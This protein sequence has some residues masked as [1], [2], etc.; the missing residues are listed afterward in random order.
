MSEFKDGCHEVTKGEHVASGSATVRAYDSA[1]VRAYDSATVRAY[2]SA[3][4]TASD[5]ATVRAYGSATVTASGSATVRAYG[6]ATVTASGSATVTASDSATVTAYGF[7]AVHVKSKTV[8]TVSGPEARIIQAS[9][10]KA[11]TKWA[12]INGVSVRKRAIRLWKCVRADGTDFRSGTISYL[13]DAVAPD[14]DPEFAGEFGNALHLA[15]SPTGARWFVPNEQI[16]TC[17]LV[18]V[19][20]LV[21]DCRCFPGNPQFPMKLRA[22]ACKFV[23]EVPRDYAGE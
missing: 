5:S 16:K 12:A 17:R 15:D 11:V 9:Y 21:K 1:T 4:V 19:E 22:R 8:K 3:T 2:D 13:S 18:E 14:W 23:R 7:S 20:A 10:P 6:S